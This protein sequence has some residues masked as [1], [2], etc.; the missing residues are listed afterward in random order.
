MSAEPQEQ[1]YAQ[2]FF[3][4]EKRKLSWSI[5][6]KEEQENFLFSESRFDKIGVV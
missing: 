3:Q 5:T 2:Y 4:D 6:R 1:E